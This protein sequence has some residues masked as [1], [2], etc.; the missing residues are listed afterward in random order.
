MSG[1]RP[2]R[3]A[4][5]G[6]GAEEDGGEGDI[7][8]GVVEDL[9]EGESIFDFGGV[10]EAGG[11]VGMDR[12]RDGQGARR[13]PWPGFDGA[14]EESDVAVF[15]RA[16]CAVFLPDGAVLFHEVGDAVGDEAGFLLDGG[17]IFGGVVVGN[18]RVFGVVRM[19]VVVCILGEEAEFD[20]GAGEGGRVGGRHGRRG[21][22]G[23]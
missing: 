6:E 19:V 7:L 3:R 4:R 14:E 10:E 16:K 2:D 8:L 23:R 12:G 9:Q 13:R 1:S 11:E 17:D 22:R 20:G 5:S 21:G 15:E 18:A